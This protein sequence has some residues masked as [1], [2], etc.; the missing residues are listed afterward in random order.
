MTMNE[1]LA[2]NV[3]AAKQHADE[4]RANLDLAREQA[5]AIATRISD[6]RARQAAITQ[7][8]LEGESTADEAAEFVAL[9]GDLE[10]LTEMHQEA[11]AKLQPLGQALAA[12]EA[13]VSRQNQA[14]ERHQA[15]EAYKALQARTAEI[16]AL[17]IRAVAAQHRAGKQLG[18]QLVSQS[19]Q[20]TRNLER[21]TRLNIVPPEV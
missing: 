1:Q 19:W 9:T 17:L 6:K 15:E 20:A 5:D 18:H 10:A 8:R 11:T 21:L 3:A 13:N 7:A 14:W 2:R 4:A 12:A 16:E